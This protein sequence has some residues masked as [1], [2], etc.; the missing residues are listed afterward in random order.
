MTRSTSETKPLQRNAKPWWRLASIRTHAIGA[1]AC[2]LVCTAIVHVY[3]FDSLSN[4]PGIA[5]GI[6]AEEAIEVLRNAQQW[7]NVYQEKVLATEQIHASIESL[8]SWIPDSVDSD[9]LQAQLE[10]ITSTNGVELL[11]F[12]YKHSVVGSRVGVA[13]YTCHLRGNFSSIG[14][15]LDAIAKLDHPISCDRIT[16][17][18]QAETERPTM[19][20]DAILSLRCPYAAEGTLAYRLLKERPS[21][22]I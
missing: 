5:N 21:H 3:R 12:A 18:H 11:S 4:N 14:R 22:G 1:T 16:L 17:G 15:M 8:S 19:S 13:V 6:S 10:I 7:R 20:C 9:E 2:L